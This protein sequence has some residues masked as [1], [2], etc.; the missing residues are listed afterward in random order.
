[1]NVQNHVYSLFLFLLLSLLLASCS[2]ESQRREL[3]P[4]EQEHGVGPVTETVQLGEPDPLLA[5]RGA[6]L[7]STYCMMCHGPGM[8]R[9]APE[10]DHLLGRRSAEYTM[11]MILNPVGM[12][13]RHPSRTQN[14]QGY[15][16]S[17][18]YQQLKVEDARALVEYFR[19]NPVL[20]AGD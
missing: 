9:I 1:M 17:M 3:T 13:R 14:Q 11:N 8:S 6:Q 20:F 4:F 5:E 2:S 16:T 18:P 12:S 7:F 10:L 19:M 15:F